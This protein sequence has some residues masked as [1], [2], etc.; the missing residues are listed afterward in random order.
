M[1]AAWL[2][3][4]TPV[5]RGASEGREQ[6]GKYCPDQERVLNTTTRGRPS[7]DVRD[8]LVPIWS[9]VLSAVFG[10]ALQQ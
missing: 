8:A 3:R 5:P 7:P 2:P 10:I 9:G 6:F 4:L 1:Q